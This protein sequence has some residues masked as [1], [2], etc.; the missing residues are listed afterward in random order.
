MTAGGHHCQCMTTPY[1]RLRCA[2]HQK[3]PVFK[4]DR[5]C[6]RCES[7]NNGVGDAAAQP[8]DV[9]LASLKAFQQQNE[10]TAPKRTHSAKHV[11][12]ETPTQSSLHS[13]QRRKSS[14]SA[15]AAPVLEMK[16]ASQKK[17]VDDQLVTPRESSSSEEQQQRGSAAASSTSGSHT[18]AT[19]A[20]KPLKLPRSRSA[21]HTKRSE[22]IQRHLQSTSALPQ[23]QAPLLR[24][25]PP[26][27][28]DGSPPFI[29]V[30]AGQAKAAWL[31]ESPYS[32][33]HLK[34]D[35]VAEMA[36]MQRSPSRRSQAFRSAL[37]LEI[38]EAMGAVRRSGSS[39]S[40][41]SAVA[42]HVRQLNA[43]NEN[44][45]NTKSSTVLIM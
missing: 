15:M 19:V 32:S 40:I 30:H 20:G 42:A 23:Y 12:I 41:S 35:A 11:T 31:K 13:T 44:A 16:T 43:K 34:P 29:T 25:P 14:R 5:Y 4:S 2:I 37:S 24:T 39:S 1:I 38:E 6:C 17:L 7:K 33:G 18:Q 26:P 21:T 28:S 8:G 22:V 27:P 10:A 36:H 3:S 9:S 45:R